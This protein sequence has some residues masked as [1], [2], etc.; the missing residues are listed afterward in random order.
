[1]FT[2][3]ISVIVL[4]IADRVFKIA[5]VKYFSDEL[6]VLIPGFIGIKV[7][8][9]GN[10]GAAFGILSGNTELLAALSAVVSVVLLIIL[11][12]NRFDRDSERWGYILVCAGAIG[13]LYDRLIEKSVTDYLEFL[14]ID[15]PVFNF[16]DVLVDVGCL[17]LFINIFFFD[18]PKKQ[19]HIETETSE[20]NE[21]I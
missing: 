6:T 8:E 20:E 18:K 15:F 5:A 7:L 10:T 3:L 4:F 14:F 21:E 12:L 13:N 19:V 11:I 9:G 2:N 16:A 1:M 17:L